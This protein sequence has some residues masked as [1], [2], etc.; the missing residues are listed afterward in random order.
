MLS[1]GFLELID[2]CLSTGKEANVYYAKAGRVGNSDVGSVGST[3]T[4]A[5]SNSDET[6]TASSTIHKT[7]NRK[8]KTRSKQALPST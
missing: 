3:T 2:G 7:D 4:A 1:N 6:L 8:F 5:N